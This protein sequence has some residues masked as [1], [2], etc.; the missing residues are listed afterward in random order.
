MNFLPRGSRSR[1]VSNLPCCSMPSTHPSPTCQLS[2]HYSSTSSIHS[3]YPSFDTPSLILPSYILFT[4]PSPLVIITYLSHLPAAHFTHSS[5]PQTTFIVVITLP[6]FPYIVSLHFP[7]ILTCTSYVAHFHCS[8]SWLPCSVS[9][10]SF[11][12][13]YEGRAVLLLL[14]PFITPLFLAHWSVD[15]SV[16]VILTG[17]PHEWGRT[18]LP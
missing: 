16:I 2:L 18:R 6:N 3:T 10:L 15:L 1:S 13:A 7:S 4:K 8:Y 14:L 17:S 11:T 9:H 5:T 12:N